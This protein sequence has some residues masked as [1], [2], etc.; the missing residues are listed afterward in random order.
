[1]EEKATALQ[2]GENVRKHLMHVTVLLAL[3]G[4]LATARGF[5]GLVD[6]I[7]GGE[8]ARPAA[9]ISQSIMALLSAGYVVLAVRSFVLARR[10]ITQ[11]P[12][13]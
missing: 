4:L 13:G 12:A 7:S 8:V 3:V 10:Q 9:A 1:M 6:L 11:P 2:V 5:A